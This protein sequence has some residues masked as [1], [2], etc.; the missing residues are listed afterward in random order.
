MKNKLHNKI[1]PQFVHL[2]LFFNKL[3]EFLDILKFLCDIHDEVRTKDFLCVFN[4]LT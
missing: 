1:I 2:K 4:L 3:L